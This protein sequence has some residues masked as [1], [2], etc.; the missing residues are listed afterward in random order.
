MVKGIKANGRKSSGII[1]VT[2]YVDV[3]LNMSKQLA[4]KAALLILA[5]VERAVRNIFF[6][7]SAKFELDRKSVV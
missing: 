4:A 2:M 5:K 3:G 6:D 1:P 7:G